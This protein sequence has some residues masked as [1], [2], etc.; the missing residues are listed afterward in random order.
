MIMF[1]FTKSFRLPTSVLLRPRMASR[2]LI[3]IL[4]YAR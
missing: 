3:L 2:I 4:I 1:T